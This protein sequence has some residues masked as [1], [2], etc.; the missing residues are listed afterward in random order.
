M[1]RLLISSLI[2]CE[3]VIKTA[4]RKSM[5]VDPKN[6][7]TLR[8]DFTCVSSDGK[9]FEI[10]MRVNTKLPFL[11]SIGLRYRSEDRIFTLCRYN[12][13]H[14]HRNKIA[15]RNKFDAFHIH[16]LYDQQLSDGLDSSIDAEV[17]EQYATFDEALYS[18][19]VD[20]HIKDWEKHFPHLEDS[21]SQLR[22]DGV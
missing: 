3:K 20:C 12:G 1:D 7:F 15:D 11:F 16:K 21:I 17:T 19:L 4:P 8:N 18:F 14:E 2:E 5:S 6:E 9:V 10:F 22:M 13:K